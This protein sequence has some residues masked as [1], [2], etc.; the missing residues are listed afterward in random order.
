MH[1][2]AIL[3]HLIT[4]GVY[5]DDVQRIRYGNTKWTHTYKQNINKYILQYNTRKQLYVRCVQINY[6]TNRNWSAWIHFT[7]RHAHTPAKSIYNRSLT[8]LAQ[9]TYSSPLYWTVSILSQ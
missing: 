6:Q 1:A 2:L 8:F 5:G 4:S 3:P 9:R 7:H